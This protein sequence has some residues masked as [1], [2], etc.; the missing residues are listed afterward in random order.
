MPAYVVSSWSHAI[1]P[2]G[3]FR[4]FCRLRS[5]KWLR[6]HDSIEWPDYYDHVNRTDL[7][8]F[9]D[10]YLKGVENGWE[11]TPPVRAR[12][13][14]T[15]EPLPK[16]GE[17]ITAKS[18]PPGTEES[19]TLT[20]FFDATRGIL[21]PTYPMQ[22]KA[23]YSHPTGKIAF[24]HKFLDD[25][26]LFGPIEMQLALSLSDATD[27]DVFIYI[28][29]VLSDGVRVGEQLVIPF[30]KGWQ[31]SILSTLHWSRL[32]YSTTKGAHFMGPRGC[33]RLS[34]RFEETANAVPGLPTMDM[35][36]EPEPVPDCE[37]L[38]VRPPIVPI[39]MRFWKNERVRVRI[40]AVDERALPPMDRATLTVEG[41]EEMNKEGSVTLFCGGEDS[42]KSSWVKVPEFVGSRA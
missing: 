3:T 16:T 29:K 2:Y 32:A 8:R 34:R 5:P 4:A 30:E 21:S 13:I 27:A 26:I 40:S 15:A 37:V 6:V 9:F 42:A 24:E 41:I 12:I 38:V 25:T 19:R 11:S 20:F 39:G 36:K 31:T 1:H 14:D 33:V 35:T 10:R 28:E 18:F 22:S 17:A 23:C 7:H